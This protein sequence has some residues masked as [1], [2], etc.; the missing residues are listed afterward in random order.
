MIAASL[1]QLVIRPNRHMA[2]AA[3]K[4]LSTAF[5]ASASPTNKCKPQQKLL[6]QVTG[7]CRGEFPGVSGNPLKFPANKNLKKSKYSIRTF[8]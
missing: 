6:I 3:V 4:G 7:A 2:V 5:A 8:K 1:P